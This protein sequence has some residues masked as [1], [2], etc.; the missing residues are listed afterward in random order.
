M[1]PVQYDTGMRETGSGSVLGLSQEVQRAVD[2][3]V[4]KKFREM[5]MD[6]DKKVGP[7]QLTAA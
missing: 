1:P 5:A 2:L 6:S 7:I 3:T 4:S